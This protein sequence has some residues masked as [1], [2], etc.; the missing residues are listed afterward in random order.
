[1]AGKIPKLAFGL[2]R[3]TGNLGLKRNILM[4]EEV[5]LKRLPFD[6]TLFGNLRRNNKI[7][8]D[9]T[10]LIAKFAK[11]KVTYFLAS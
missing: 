9:K 10:G 8:V 4:S 7:Y 3:G 1:M 11:F 6:C 2:A 5:N